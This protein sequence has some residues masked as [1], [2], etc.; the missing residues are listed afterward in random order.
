M[1]SSSM[2]KGSLGY[3]GSKPVKGNSIANGGGNHNAAAHDAKGSQ[4]PGPKLDR[5]KGVNV[6]GLVRSDEPAAQTTPKRTAS[7]TG[8]PH[9]PAVE[10]LGKG[11]QK[12]NRGK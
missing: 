6:N 7:W 8:A 3:G 2:W 5:V 11:I 4:T 9:A 12:V 1:V 10:K